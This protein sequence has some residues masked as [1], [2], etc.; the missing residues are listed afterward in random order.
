MHI[1]SNWPKME[2]WAKRSLPD[3]N[4]SQKLGPKQN[5]PW[6]DA[7]S[8]KGRGKS[9]GEDVPGKARGKTKSDSKRLRADTSRRNEFQAVRHPSVCSAKLA[10]RTARITRLLFAQAVITIFLPT[11]SFTDHWKENLKRQ[12]RLSAQYSGGEI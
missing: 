12:C 9:K 2:S 11:N 10:L 8:S 3:A 1:C 4:A 5:R 7:S 6:T